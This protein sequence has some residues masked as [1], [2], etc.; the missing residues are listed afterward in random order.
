MPCDT[1]SNC[2]DRINE[3]REIDYNGI[4]SSNVVKPFNDVGDPA[5]TTVMTYVVDP[6]LF[7]EVTRGTVTA[8]PG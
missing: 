8:G 7:V 5:R 4:N 6:A 1:F 2:V 3:T